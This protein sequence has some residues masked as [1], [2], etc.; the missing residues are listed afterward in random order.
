MTNFRNAG[1]SLSLVIIS[2]LVPVVVM[3][4]ASSLGGASAMPAQ[5][6]SH[7]LA[8]LRGCCAARLMTMP[9]PIELPPRSTR[10]S[11]SA[12]TNACRRWAWAE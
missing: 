2:G 5:S 3:I 6:I 11:P 8:T 10:A 9:P 4:L 7:R 12:S 1:K